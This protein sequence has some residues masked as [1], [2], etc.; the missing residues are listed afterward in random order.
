M[1]FAELGEKCEIL[2]IFV[3]EIGGFCFK[4]MNARIITAML[5]L[6]GFGT[7]C[8]GVK[9]S[10]KGSAETTDSLTVVRPIRLMYGVPVRDF[11]ARPLV[12]TTRDASRSEQPDATA[13]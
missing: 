3:S 11:Q 10:A 8:S 5:A 2:H 1:F 12:D 6:L 13:E 9:R 4:N 7:A